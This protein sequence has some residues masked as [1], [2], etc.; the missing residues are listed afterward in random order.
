M[1][2]TQDLGQVI[3][4]ILK[5]NVVFETEDWALDQAQRVNARLQAVRGQGEPF[6]IEIPWLEEFTAFTAPGRYI[7][8]SRSLFQLLRHDDMTALVIAHEM[9]HH[10]LGHLQIFPDWLTSVAAREKGFMLFTL[11]R[12]AE[13]RVHGPQ[14]ESA[15]DEYAMDLC[16]N[17]G[18][19]GRKCLELFDVLQKH[20]LDVRDLDGVFGLD[21]PVDE[22]LQG[23]SWGTKAR[24]W[25]QQRVRGYPP[26]IERRRLLEEQFARRRRG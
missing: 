11:F 3:F 5:D 14:I 16:L 26:I 13:R 17:A 19:D 12:A 10:D 20:A 15:A 7:F 8:I 9:G 21:I 6:Q 18:F 4:D 24:D 22:I 23:I 1:S 2:D 25:F